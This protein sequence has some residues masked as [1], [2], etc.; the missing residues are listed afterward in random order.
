MEKDDLYPV[1][2]EDLDGWR[3][4]QA[5]IVSRHAPRGR[6]SQYERVVGRLQ[7]WLVDRYRKAEAR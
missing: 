3:R 2:I 4:Y 1:M 6:L 5:G 7:D